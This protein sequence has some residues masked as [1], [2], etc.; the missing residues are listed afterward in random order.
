MLVGR[1]RE[2]A[3]LDRLFADAR[4]GRS[5][6]LALVGEAGVGKSALLDAAASR[7]DSMLVLRARG[8]Q[9]ETHIPFAGLLELLRPALGRLGRIPLP[10]AAALEGALALRPARAKDR[11]AVGAATL[12]LIASHA[13]TAPVAVLVDDAHWL[14][15]S[16]ADALLFA[17]RR[18]VADP[19][20]ILLTVRSGEPSLLDGAD[21]PTL[22]VVGLGA[23]AATE[24]LRRAI[25]EIGE[26]TVA[27]LQQ[28][29]GGNPLALLELVREPLPELPLDVPV[30]VVTSV[31][32]AYL[33]RASTLPDR[34][35][36]LL[37]LA[38]V[39]DRGEL[40]LLSRAAEA[41]ELDVAHLA[42]AE[43]AGLLTIR[44]GRVE[45]CH[46]LARSA[47]YAE[48]EPE[49]R[50]EAHRTLAR[51]LSTDDA[52]R[53][54][55]HLGLAALGPDADA[56]AELEQAARRAHERSA[57][58]VAASAF[59]QA[60]HLTGDPLERSRLLLAAA[61][62]AWLGGLPVR[63]ADLL[64]E[65]SHGAPAD[66]SVRIRH[67]QGRIALRRGPLESGR[68][69]LLGAA[70]EAASLDPA[71]AILM[72]AEAAQGAFYAADA[73][74]MRTC[75]DRATS[76]QERAGDDQSAFFAG[77]THGMA[78]VLS[79]EGEVG[80]AAIRDAVHLLERTAGLR[81]D[82]RLLVWAALGPIWLRESGVGREIVDRAV[83]TARAASAAGVLPH[84]LAHVAIEHAATD[85]WIEAQAAFDEAIGL[86]RETGQQVVL[87]GALSRLAWLEARLGREDASERHADEALAISRELG[88]TL[89]ET[90]ALAALGD[91]ELGRGNVAE[92]LARL[93]ELQDVVAG[94]AIA[95]A[96]VSPAPEQVEL[97]LRAGRRDEAAA[98]AGEFSRAAEAKAQ[99][100]A[101]ARSL[102]CR[103][104]LAD[105]DGFA[106]AFEGALD[107]HVQTP[108]VFETARTEL[109]YGARLRRAG[110]RTAA[111][112]R[113]RAALEVFDDLG[114]R[115]WGDLARSELHATGETA[116]RRE[117][118]RLDELTAQELQVS[119]LLAEGRTTREAAAALFLSPKTIEYHLR[120][121]YRK[122]A[123]HSRPELR[124]ALHALGRETP[125][126]PD[127]A[128]GQATTR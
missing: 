27:R 102:R 89:C 109:A 59:A 60:A 85:R 72:L 86:A 100:W 94:R 42:P 14:D 106:A 16:S 51:V 112:E 101:Q 43:R 47:L 90:W 41:L 104:L 28:E 98:I 99:P 92:A 83:A 49:R 66:V 46:P 4:S 114:A 54:A 26:A 31:A 8:V 93:S 68:S 7:T 21:L 19:V 95:D 103:G 124:E 10:Q 39:T 81:S 5:A 111:R 32:R 117:P 78:L 1:E 30:P 35:R 13:E 36:Q 115:P 62:D 96:D 17:A 44:D 84:L 97:L 120:N 126:R 82:P 3:Q 125:S 56:A 24:L 121:V 110:R 33:E 61:D 45:F 11:F 23:A 91:L 57:Y 37:L 119:L 22:P 118:S 20:G 71:L 34:T 48:G 15:G 52:D 70:D 87:A 18:L 58:E 65:G 50:R 123:I 116:R 113:L 2:L 80:A 9:S 64:E 40:G 69:I 25:P 88:V 75:A 77:M 38:S 53:R 74:G 105:D 107:L 55:W 76:L 73:A 128:R 127:P 79:G 12:S 67:L 63:A 108:D 29:T 6:T 122:L